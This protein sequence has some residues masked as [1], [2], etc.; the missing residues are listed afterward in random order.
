MGLKV[1]SMLGSATSVC[2]Y[3]ARVIIAVFVC[4]LVGIIH[5]V[6]IGWHAEYLEVLRESC[7]FN[8]SSVEVVSGAK[9]VLKYHRKQF[10]NISDFSVVHFD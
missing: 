8:N 10:L 1:I 9:K 3:I 6:L 5:S 7:F 4:G 2:G